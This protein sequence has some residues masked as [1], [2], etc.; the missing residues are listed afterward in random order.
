[1]TRLLSATHFKSP[2]RAPLSAL[3]AALRLSSLLADSCNRSFTRLSSVSWRVAVDRIEETT[4]PFSD[5]F[6]RRV[7][8]ES[9]IGSLTIQIAMDR[10][11]ISAFM[12]AVTGGSGTEAPFDIGERP[13]SSIER[14]TLGIAC[15][16]LASDIGQSL[17]AH[18]ARP[19]S[20]FHEDEPGDPP[21]TI[22]EMAT[23]RLLV[24]V[25]GYSGELRLSMA[26]NELTH[27]IE[28]ASSG[29]EDVHAG[30]AHQELQRQVGRS[31]V[32]FIVTL[33]P[34][35]LSVEHLTALRPGEMIALSSTVS[36]PVTLWSG[37]VAAFRG[38]LA[39]SGDRLAVI[40]TSAVN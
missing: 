5:M 3:P 27:Q 31:D 39:R 9:T 4:A 33:G 13:L 32:E 20:Y 38:N 14:A 15:D 40:I 10:S 1:M 16:A 36:T 17:S 28:G 34:Q 2:P 8:L 21:L 7:R 29:S 24:N 30:V 6:T 22:Q 18:F 37:G 25:F 23:F 26:R 12:E 35:T 19:F 11:L